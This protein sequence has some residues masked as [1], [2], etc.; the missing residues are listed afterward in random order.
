LS[1]H[2]PE[3]TILYRSQVGYGYQHRF[4]CYDDDETGILPSADLLQRDWENLINILLLPHNP[5]Y[6][7]SNPNSLVAATNE[8]GA[9]RINDITNS[10][11]SHVFI[12][13]RLV[14]T[15]FHTGTIAPSPYRNVTAPRNFNDEQ[16]A[17]LTATYASNLITLTQQINS[18]CDA[19][20]QLYNAQSTMNLSFNNEGS[21]SNMP[22]SSFA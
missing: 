22:Y 16:R 6:D 11:K 5:A 10:Q 19:L 9:P 20:L 8:S 3:G 14:S 21:P 13:I 7:A 15:A 12:W 18:T 1:K 4:L 2:Y 17:A